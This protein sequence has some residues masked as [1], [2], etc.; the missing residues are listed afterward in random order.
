MD[1]LTI[2]RVDKLAC[3]CV[4]KFTSWGAYELFSWC[5]DDLLSSKRFRFSSLERQWACDLHCSEDIER[6]AS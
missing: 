1:K 2:R 5:I 6:T 3:L 4:S